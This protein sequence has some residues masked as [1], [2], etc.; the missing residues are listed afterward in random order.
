MKKLNFLKSKLK[1][2]NKGVF[3]DLRKRKSTIT[4]DIER[5][6][7]LEQGNLSQDLIALRNLRRK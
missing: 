6:E 2:W 3:G 1:E 4:L 5:I 7:R